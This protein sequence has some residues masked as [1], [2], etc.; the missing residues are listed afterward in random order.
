MTSIKRFRVAKNTFKL[1]T[2]NEKMILPIL[3]NAVEAI[4][5]IFLLQ[6]NTINNGAN[7]YPRD[8]IKTE[9]SKFAKSDPKILSPFSIVKRSKNN[10][11]VATEYH[12]EYKDLLTPISKKLLNAASKSNN[13]SFKKYLETLSKALIDGSYEKADAAWLKVNNSNL[14]VVIGPYERY[15]DKLFFVK[16]AYQGSVSIIDPQK[17]VEATKIRDVLYSTIANKPKRVKPPS[18]VDI[19]AKYPLIFSGFLGRV[20]FTQQHLPSESK[21][22]EKYGS[23]ISAY[24]SPLD[25]KF[26]SLIFPIFNAVF[27]SKFK[28]RYTRKLIK[29]GCYFHIILQGIVQHLHRYQ[30]S[31]KR[32]RELFPIVDE[33]NTVAAGIQQAKYLLLKGVI[34]QKQLESMMI[35]QI[36]WF[37]SEVV[38]SRKS[39]A[40]DVYLK[41]DL[42]V[43][44]FL[45][46]KGA[47]QI[48]DGLSWPNFAKMFFEM[49]NLASIFTRIMEEDT[50]EQAN[51]FINK[52]MYLDAY[53]Q[54]NKNLENIKPI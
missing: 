31:R 4:D 23:Q 15:L 19:K 20:L 8:A 21:S 10:E 32:L 43:Y 1:L 5:K 53:D 50:Y 34:S 52:Y 9:I 44:N 40:R 7:F 46:R 36:C 27:E 24:L 11:L 25:Y 37:F 29:E 18:T 38:Y 3:E 14:D 26:N 47:L 17:S 30:G 35:A 51:T 6:E 48:H 12:K 42:L 41:G 39:N 45:E 22:I 33:A 13:K 28:S 2:Q 54:F 49:E 16:R